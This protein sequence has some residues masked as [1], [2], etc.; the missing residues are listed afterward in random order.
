MYNLIKM[1]TSPNASAGS[2][3]LNAQNLALQPQQQQQFMQQSQN[4]GNLNGTSSIADGDNGDNAS[5][6]SITTGDP[7]ADPNADPNVAT[8]PPADGKYTLA[9]MGS[10]VRTVFGRDSG[11]EVFNSTAEKYVGVTRKGDDVTNYGYYYAN[12]ND[13][14]TNS[15][16][17]RATAP[18]SDAAEKD[19]ATKISDAIRAVIPTTKVDGHNPITELALSDWANATKSFK[20]SGENKYFESNKPLQVQTLDGLVPKI[21]TY[22]KTRSTFQMFIDYD[23]V[24]GNITEGIGHLQ[25]FGASN[26]LKM[27]DRLRNEKFT[28][29]DGNITLEKGANVE[30]KKLIETFTG[31]S[32]TVNESQPVVANTAGGK[33]TR[34]KRKN[35]RKKG[36]VKKPVSHKKRKSGAS[37]K[38]RSHPKKK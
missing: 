12:W 18:T 30:L 20:F 15:T 36:G 26:L 23:I 6:N 22:N 17:F 3:A 29:K 13:T 32:V 21:E 31:V 37:K 28:I 11:E 24:D 33:S 8:P 4:Q 2:G 38:K 5:V 10:L 19:A 35:S 27:G 9:V 16:L 34:K 1:S 14:K 7:N 25:F